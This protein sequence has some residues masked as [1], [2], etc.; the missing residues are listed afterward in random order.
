MLLHM[1][2]FYSRWHRASDCTDTRARPTSPAAFHPRQQHLIESSDCPRRHQRLNPVRR[3][4][5]RRALPDAA[6]DHRIAPRQHFDEGGV[7]AA[8]LRPRA[9]AV[10][11]PLANSTTTKAADRAR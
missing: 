10:R 9:R 8:G 4:R 7:I 5:H 11:S 2:T 6:A 3:Q 1:S